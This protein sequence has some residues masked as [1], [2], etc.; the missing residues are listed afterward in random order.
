MTGGTG[1]PSGGPRDF[2]GL[3]AVVTGGTSGIG[4]ATA[5]L[6]RSRGA[7]VASL[8]LTPAEGADDHLPLVCDVRSTASVQAA[9]DATIVRW[10]QLDVV[11]NNAGVEARGSILD[12]DDEEWARVLDVNVTGMARV[13]RA[14][15]S[16]LRHSDAAVVVNTCSIAALRGMPGLSLYSASKGAVLA[17]THALAA[18]LLPDGI[19][20]CCVSPGTVDTPWVGRILASSAD[21]ATALERIKARQP[22]GRLVSATEVAAAIVFLASPLMSAVTGVCLPV[23]GGSAALSLAALPP[24]GAS[25]TDVSAHPRHIPDDAPPPINEAV[26]GDLSRSRQRPSQG[27]S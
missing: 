21:P 3:V 18:D 20:V 10:G 6:L 19:R 8:D 5:R 14:A 23:D 16:H 4:A 25:P 26:R 17:L 11:V 7:R 24:P 13:V 2:D 12:H 1:V 9:I 27:A 22:D 15:L